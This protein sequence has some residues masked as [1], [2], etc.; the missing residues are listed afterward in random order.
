MFSNIKL[1]GIFVLILGIISGI[2]YW[3]Y[4]DSQQTI[5]ALRE[6]NAKLEVAIQLSEET[7]AAIKAD[8]ARANEEI[9]RVNRELSEARQQNRQLVDKLAKHDLET[10]AASKPKLVERTINNAT[11][12]ANRC[13]ELLTGAELTEKERNAKNGKEFNSECP[14]LYDSLGVGR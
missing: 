12:K 14:W 10:L 11:D 2:F 7:L 4:K 1:I 5:S 6:N 9:V 8:Q 13:I 3:Y